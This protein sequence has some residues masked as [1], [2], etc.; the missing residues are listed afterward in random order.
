MSICTNR[1]VNNSLICTE[2]MSER[3]GV[4]VSHANDQK[5][6]ERKHREKKILI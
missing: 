5:R 4:P 1:P 3:Y 6:D 2:T